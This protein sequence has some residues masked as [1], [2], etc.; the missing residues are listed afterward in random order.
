MRI[1]IILA[2]VISPGVNFASGHLLIIGGGERPPAVI[3]KFVQLA[4]A[5]N[6]KIVIIPVASSIP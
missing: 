4:G 1:L 3:Q 5:E 6:A 2:V